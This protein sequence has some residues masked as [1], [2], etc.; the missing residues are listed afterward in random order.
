MDD[1]I[2]LTTRSAE[3]LIVL[4]V[5]ASR[6]RDWADVESILVRQHA[7]LDLEYVRRELPPLLE[8]K[9]DFSSLAKLEQ[10]CQFV[11]RRV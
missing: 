5:F 10:L 9:N 6:D 2:S 8:L 3:D 11:T 7:R 1:A 4:K